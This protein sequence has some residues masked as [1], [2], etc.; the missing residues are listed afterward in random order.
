MTC[1]PAAKLEHPCI[2]AASRKVARER[3]PL[4]EVEEVTVAGVAATQDHRRS[5]LVSA[6]VPVER[7]IPA[8]RGRGVLQCPSQRRIFGEGVVALHPYLPKMIPCR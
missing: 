3:V 5:F 8:V 7:E 2:E 6:V 1:A 4:V